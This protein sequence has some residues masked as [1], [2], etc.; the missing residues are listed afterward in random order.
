MAIQHNPQSAQYYVHRARCQQLMQNIF[1]AR[2]DIAT[3]LLLNPKQPKVG[4]CWARKAG[5]RVSTPG[6]L[7]I[8]PVP[9]RNLV[10]KQIIRAAH[11]G[12]F[13]MSQV[14]S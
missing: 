3:A 1:G 13:T 2:Q 5:S 10:S 4:S 14:L 12:A 9:K 7:K 11:A 6:H 8:L